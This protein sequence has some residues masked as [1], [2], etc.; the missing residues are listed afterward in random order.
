MTIRFALAK[1]RVA[2]KAIALLTEI[3]YCFEDYTPESRKLIFQ[4]TTGAIEFFLVKSPDVGTYVEK[5]A[6]DIGIVGRDVLMEHP[7][8]VYELLNLNIGQCKMC[9]AGYADT[10]IQFDKK[11]VVGTKYPGIAKQ[12]FNSIDQPIDLIMINGSVELAPILGLSDC[13]VDIVES[14]STLKEN[15][16]VVLKEIC[17]ISSRLIVNQVSLKIKRK[18][19]EPIIDRFSAIAQ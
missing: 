11:L 7:A 4:D 3:G 18:E 1:G 14:G 9:V 2:K 13:I 8:N 19:I 17:D 5:G 15:G 12:Y 6:A 16:L 10:H